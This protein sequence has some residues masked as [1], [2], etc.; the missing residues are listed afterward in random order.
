MLAVLG[1]ASMTG[2]VV[3]LGDRLRF[4]PTVASLRPA[5]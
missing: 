1:T 5:R 4:T 2:E 3:G